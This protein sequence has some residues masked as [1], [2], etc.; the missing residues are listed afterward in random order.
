MIKNYRNFIYI[1]EDVQTQEEMAPLE[2]DKDQRMKFVKD[3]EQFLTETNYYH[4]SS[5][6]NIEWFKAREDTFGLLGPGV[7]FYK[8]RY[9][10]K[11]HGKY[12]Y[13]ISISP[14]GKAENLIDEPIQLKIMPKDYELNDGQI[15]GLFTHLKIPQDLRKKSPYGVQR[16]LWWYTD[17]WKYYEL[18]REQTAVT[19]TKIFRIS[20]DGMVAD[21]PKSGEVLVLWKRYDEIK[22]KQ[23]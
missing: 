19:L 23:E 1:K 18:D 9:F 4:G 16:P 17:G 12:T 8:N 21:Y 22:L 13:S 7:Y 6:N 10:T 14:K 20:F 5:E 11:E 3:F 2:K 15:E